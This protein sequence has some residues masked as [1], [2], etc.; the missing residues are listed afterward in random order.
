MLRQPSL[1]ASPRSPTRSPLSRCDDDDA[2]ASSR[3][4]AV[5][6]PPPPPVTDA[7]RQVEAAVA[8]SIYQ[9]P[10]PPPRMVVDFKRSGKKDEL[11]VRV[12]VRL[13]A[14]PIYDPTKTEKKIQVTVHFCRISSI[15][16]LEYDVVKEKL[17]QKGK[18]EQ[19]NQKLY[20]SVLEV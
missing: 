11:R 19:H 14:G 10:P 9:P 20:F 2:P 1:R 13:R 7:E 5:S 16:M 6:P 3:D 8:S 17:E 12:G 15:T 4:P 18:T